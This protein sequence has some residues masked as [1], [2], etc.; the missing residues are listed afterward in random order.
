MA[1]A[2][3]RAFIRAT[4]ERRQRTLALVTVP[5]ALMPDLLIAWGWMK[6]SDGGSASFWTAI[7]VM[8]IVEFLIWVKRAGAAWAIFHGYGKW[9]LSKMIADGLRVADFP[10]PLPIESGRDYLARVEGD[11]ALSP[12]VRNQAKSD[13]ESLDRASEKGLVYGLRADA[14]YDRAVNRLRKPESY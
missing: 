4:F 6:L 1:T 14:I 12:D 2:K 8:W 10:P 7:A 9:A 3:E 11:E 5:I 13:F